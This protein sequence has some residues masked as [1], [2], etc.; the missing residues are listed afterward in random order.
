MDFDC[1]KDYKIYNQGANFLDVVIPSKGVP[2]QKHLKYMMQ[3]LE[4]VRLF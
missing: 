1:R 4:Y 3:P 2:L